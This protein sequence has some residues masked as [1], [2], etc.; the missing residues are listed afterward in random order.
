MLFEILD[1]A[2]TVVSF[3]KCNVGAAEELRCALPRRQRWTRALLFHAGGVLADSALANQTAAAARRVF[4]PKGEGLRK[5]AGGQ[6]AA[7]GGA[8]IV[9]SSIAALLGS[10]G[11]A[12]YCAAN[13]V[14]DFLAAR[15][16]QG[17]SDFKSVQWGPWS[18]GGMAAKLEAR[19]KRLGLGMVT[20]QMGM[21]AMEWLVR[22]AGT[23][24]LCRS[25]ATVAVQPFFPA[26][27]A[28]MDAVPPLF[29]ELAEAHAAEG[30]ARP[31]RAAP[32]GV[33]ARGGGPGR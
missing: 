12:N 9:F 5:L 3:Q 29:A 19:M 16:A 10:A 28:K 31:A 18:G 24:R 33:H 27:F 14:L 21:A 30:G 13:S 15:M 1:Q 23:Q 4:A 32:A 7:A 20:Q 2:A 17:G 25:E 6:V 11:Q 22:N 8:T 26:F